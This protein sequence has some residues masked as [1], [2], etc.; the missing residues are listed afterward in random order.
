MTETLN[1]HDTLNVYVFEGYSDNYIYRSNLRG[2]GVSVFCRN[3]FNIENIHELSMCNATIDTCAVLI[4]IPGGYLVILR[5]YRPHTDSINNCTLQLESVFKSS[6]HKNAKLVLLAGDMNV[7]LLDM[8]CAPV[9]NYV[10]MPQ[11]QQFLS[12]FT[13]PTTFSNN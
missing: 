7:N 11:S 10:C 4:F 12:T 1:S 9:K 8:K 13:E 6:Y 5:V 2:G 3:S